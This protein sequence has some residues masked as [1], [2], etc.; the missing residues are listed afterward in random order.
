MCLFLQLFPF[1]LI[2]QNFKITFCEQ[3]LFQLHTVCPPKCIHTLTADG[4]ALKM[5]CVFINAAFLITYCV[6]ALGGHLVCYK[7]FLPEKPHL[8]SLFSINRDDQMAFLV[9]L[10]S[11]HCSLRIVGWTVRQGERGEGHCVITACRGR[12]SVL[13]GPSS[14]AKAETAGSSEALGGAGCVSPCL[15]RA[16]LASRAAVESTSHTVTRLWAVGVP[17]LPLRHEKQSAGSRSLRPPA[18]S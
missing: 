17:L 10:S 18:I 14:A 2:F 15:F 5:K 7:Y 4:S 11:R 13:C 16:G 9:S 12:W 3:F 8:F 1:L 6:Y